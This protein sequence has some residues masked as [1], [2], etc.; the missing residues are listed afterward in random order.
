[1]ACIGGGGVGERGRRQ[2]VIRLEDGRICVA[3]QVGM[4]SLSL[5]ACPTA[6]GVICFLCVWYDIVL[7]RR[8]RPNFY[9]LFVLGNALWIELNPPPPTPPARSLCKGSAGWDYSI[10]PKH[11]SIVLICSLRCLSECGNPCRRFV[12]R[13]F[14]TVTVDTCV[15]CF[16]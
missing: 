14:G 2:G 4:S 11:R 15:R 8:R 7:R 9:A 6:V 12:F 5:V 3:S 1:M 16:V 13:R 10:L